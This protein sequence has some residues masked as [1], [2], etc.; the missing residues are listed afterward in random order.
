MHGHADVVIADDGDLTR[1][2]AHAD[3]HL[4]PVSPGVP[5]RTELGSQGCMHAVGR[6]GERNEEGVALGADLMAAVL[7]HRGPHDPSML[8][9]QVR[10][11]VT[12]GA[13]QPGRPFDVGEQEGDRPGWG[14]RRRILCSEGGGS[15]AAGRPGHPLLVLTNAQGRQLATSLY[16]RVAG[17]M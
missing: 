5:A 1:V 9:R 13:E 14:P 15:T 16:D 6:A 4:P 17:S 11:L 2:E 3:A 10:I 7:C 8:L 12:R